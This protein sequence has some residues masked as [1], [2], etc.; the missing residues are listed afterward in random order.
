MKMAEASQFSNVF[1]NHSYFKGRW[2]SEYFKN[3]NP[4]CLELGCG[5]GDFTIEMSRKYPN[6]NFIGV[7]I[8]GS[9][10]WKGAKTALMGGVKTVAFLRIHIESIDDYFTE[11]EVNEIWITFPDPYPESKREK[12]RLTSPGFLSIYKKILKTGEK[13]HLKTDDIKLFQYTL[14][15]VKS[16]KFHIHS[17]IDDLYSQVFE[18]TGAN[19]ITGY[20]RKYLDDGKSIKYLSFSFE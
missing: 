5:K 7:D 13:I 17:S 15:L 10:L 4:I 6:V 14:D 3:S 12:K 9:R 16:E 8:K 1:E 18:N 2:N 19:V 20:E 11:N